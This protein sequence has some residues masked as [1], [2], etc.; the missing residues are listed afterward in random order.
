MP[1][2]WLTY[3][4]LAMLIGCDASAARTAA[5]TIPLDLRKSH[6]G[7]T[8]AKLDAQLTEIFLDRLTQH[9]IDREIAMCAADLHVLRERMLIRSV[10]TESASAALAS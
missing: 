2:I 7:R 10:A 3:D 5:H 6:D 8:R 4:E 1:Q 9:R